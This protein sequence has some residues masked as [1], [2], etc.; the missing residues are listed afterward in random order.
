MELIDRLCKARRSYGSTLLTP[1]RVWGINLIPHQRSCC[2]AN[3]PPS[4]PQATLLITPSHMHGAPLPIPLYPYGVWGK[5][6]AVDSDRVSKIFWLT[7]ATLKT[8]KLIITILKKEKNL[9]L[10]Y[11]IV[12]FFS[13]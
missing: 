8:L 10:C 11:T 6:Q 3:L 2:K 13:S 1:F 9:S 4:D 5:M 12:I 7:Y